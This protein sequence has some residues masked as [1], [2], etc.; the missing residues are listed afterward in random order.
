MLKGWRRTC[1]FQGRAPQQP[2]GQTAPGG[3]APSLAGAPAAQQELFVGM[4]GTT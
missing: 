4:L 3:A 2:A 1:P